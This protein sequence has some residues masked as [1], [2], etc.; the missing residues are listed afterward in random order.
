LLETLVDVLRL[1]LHGWAD[2]ITC[3]VSWL[4][5]MNWTRSPLLRASKALIYERLHVDA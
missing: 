2:R 3:G 4:W 5:L 1:I